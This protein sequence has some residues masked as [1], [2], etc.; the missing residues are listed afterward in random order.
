LSLSIFGIII[1]VPFNLEL[2][3]STSLFKELIYL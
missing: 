2:A 3:L 1:P